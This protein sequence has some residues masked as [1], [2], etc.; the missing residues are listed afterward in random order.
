[1]R[2]AAHVVA[3]VL[4]LLSACLMYVLYARDDVRYERESR[5]FIQGMAAGAKVMLALYFLERGGIL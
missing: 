1:M 3:A 4:L 2:M 5:R